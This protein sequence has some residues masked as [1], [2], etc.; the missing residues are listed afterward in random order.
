MELAV[1]ARQ[2]LTT[3][4]RRGIAVARAWSGNLLTALEMP[5]C[6]LSVLAVDDVMLAALDAPTQAPAWPGNGRVPDAPRVL[7]APGKPSAG[8]PSGPARA[9]VGGGGGGVVRA[10]IL[11]CAE[12]LEAARD[13]L[14]EL[15]SAAGDGDLGISMARG[16]AALRAVPENEWGDAPASL[17]LAGDTLRRAI[18][19]S[20]GPFYAVALLRAA[21]RLEQAD[22]R[23]PQAWAAAFAD[24]VAAIAALGGA[25]PGDRTMLDAL[26]PAVEALRAAFAAGQNPGEAW[27]ACLV[28]CADGVAR[29]AAMLP[30]VGRASYLGARAVGLPDAGAAAVEVWL[31]ALTPFVAG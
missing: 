12:A 20:S 28:A 17:V 4:R 27:R 10:A 21:R 2:A 7:A 6:S 1:V 29:T 19:G 25:R 30:R 31:G 15:D 26:Q 24:A 13:R 14:T 18:G 5:G 23:S 22:G 16:A 11:A 8:S 3:L 9:S